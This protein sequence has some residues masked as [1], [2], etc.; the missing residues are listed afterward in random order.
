MA[1]ALIKGLQKNSSYIISGHDR[2][3]ANLAW[4]EHETIAQ[5]SLENICTES[6]IVVICVRPKDMYDL[7]VS[8][9]NIIRDD[10]KIVSVAA[11]VTLEN[12]KTALP[13]RRIYR[14]MPNIGAKDN[15]G[16]TSI[17]SSEQDDE[18]LE[19]FNFLGKAFR[20]D[21][22]EKINLHTSLI[23][24]GP[25]FYFEIINEFENRLDELLPNSVSK[26]DIT[27]LFLTSLISAIKNGENL[28]DLIASIKSKGGTTEAGLN[29]LYNE[30]FI[31]IFSDAIDTAK[32]RA[33]ELSMD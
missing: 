6:D 5:Q 12:L 10:I 21:N 14:A 26:R 30:N 16:I 17:F 3:E 19:I 29:L 11:G 31:K 7:C 27:L 4:L 22:E 20:V 24:S 2:N 23:G 32:N 25:A 13:G 28:E 1:K 18:I 9:N 15:L 8:M 33:T